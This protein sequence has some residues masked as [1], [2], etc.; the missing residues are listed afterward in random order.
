MSGPGRP[1]ISFKLKCVANDGTTVQFEGVGRDHEN[2]ATYILQPEDA[3]YFV[4]GE[5]YGDAFMPA[6]GSDSAGTD[7][8]APQSQS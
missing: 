7:S 1:G 5:V 3:L 8:A 2:R 6:D 4:V